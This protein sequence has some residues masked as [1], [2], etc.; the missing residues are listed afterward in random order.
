MKIF[1][2]KYNREYTK[3]E[4]FEAGIILSGAEVKSIKTGNLKIDDAYVK[5][6]NGVPYLINADISLYKFAQPNASYDSKRRR[7]LL[8]R[9]KELIKIIT[10]SKSQGLTLIPIVCYTKHNLIKLLI[11]LSK[12]KKDWEKRRGEKAKKIALRAKIEAK[13]YLKR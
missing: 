6:F 13:E 4:E 10:R 9:K 8:L 2:R 11:A 7:Q 1:N 5:I 12:G 3:I